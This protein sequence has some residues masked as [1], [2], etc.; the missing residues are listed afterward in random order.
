MP[1]QNATSLDK[2]AF[3]VD[4]LG[5]AE[6]RFGLGEN[7]FQ[8]VEMKNLAL[9]ATECQ[10]LFSL[11]YCSGRPLGVALATTPATI[12]TKCLGRQR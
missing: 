11:T 6:N 4:L 1:Q 10:T 8:E 7:R 12:C 3:K 9:H 5:Y 2:A